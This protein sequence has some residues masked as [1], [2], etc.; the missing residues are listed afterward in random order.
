MHNIY[1]Q[2]DAAWC[3]FKKNTVISPLYWCNRNSNNATGEDDF[4]FIATQDLDT[5]QSSWSIA[6]ELGVFVAEKL[7]KHDDLSRIWLL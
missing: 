4:Q 5:N 6:N 2:G 1:L 3:V 7:K